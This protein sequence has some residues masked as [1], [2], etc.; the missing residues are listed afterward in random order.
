[1]ISAIEVEMV[2]KVVGLS[3]SK[4][5][6]VARSKQDLARSQH[7]GRENAWWL[8]KITAERFLVLKAHHSV[9]FLHAI[10]VLLSRRI[11]G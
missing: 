7:G 3:W 2:V 8:A 10:K 11:C 5:V 4:V 1:M 9:I 6:V